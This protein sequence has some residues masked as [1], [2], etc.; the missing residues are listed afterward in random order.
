MPC[1]AGR[2][3]TSTHRATIGSGLVKCHVYDGASQEVEFH[4]SNWYG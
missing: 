2:G 4:R 3:N 1:T